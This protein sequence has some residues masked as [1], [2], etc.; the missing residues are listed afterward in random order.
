MSE[1]EQLFLVG[2]EPELVVS[3]SKLKAIRDELRRVRAANTVAG[4]AAGWRQFERWCSAAGRSPL[5]SSVET[6]ELFATHQLQVDGLRATTVSHR[7]SAIVDAHR[8]AGLQP[9]STVGVR[10]ILTGARHLRRESPRGKSALA[11]PDL[12]RI[13]VEL[14]KRGGARNLR[15]RALIVLGVASGLRRSNL[16]ALD[17][18]D[19][20]FERRGLVLSIGHS[21]TDQVGEGVRLG[22]RYGRRAGTCPVRTLRA[23]LKLRGR[24]AGPLFSRVT[25][26]GRVLPQRLSGPAVAEAVQRAVE[27]VGLDPSEYG[28]HSLRAACATAAHE[29]GASD[30]A[31]MGRTGHASVGMLR[32]YIRGADPFAVDPLAGVL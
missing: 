4:Y 25:A 28:G 8:R 13:S 26:G 20:R 6:V 24:A 31:I 29:R 21:K 15:D 17:L 18:S 16:S 19:V 7:I 11:I 32:R 1:A 27:L 3:M 12:R 9:P 2:C 5:P 22:L 23:W 14:R 30:S 10:A